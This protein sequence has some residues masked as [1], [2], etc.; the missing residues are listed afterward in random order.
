MLHLVEV[1]TYT[2]GWGLMGSYLK[3]AD[4]ETHSQ[5]GA[6]IDTLLF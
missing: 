2:H 4:S 3:F 6:G 1:V 5:V